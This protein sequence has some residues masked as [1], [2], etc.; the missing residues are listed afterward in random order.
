MHDASNMSA[1]ISNFLET[2]N[3]KNQRGRPRINPIGETTIDGKVCES[4]DL[5]VKSHGGGS[6]RIYLPYSWVG[7]R[8]LVVKLEG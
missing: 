2:G 8:V 3:V 4:V 7:S 5:I 1:F 6:G